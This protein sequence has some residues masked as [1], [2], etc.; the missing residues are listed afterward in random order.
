MSYSRET[1]CHEDE[2]CNAP[3]YDHGCLTLFASPSS[4]SGDG[5][6]DDEDQD[7]SRTKLG[8]VSPGTQHSYWDRDLFMQKDT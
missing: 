5:G 1:C 3:T 7:K 8:Q 4:P 6:V 2:K